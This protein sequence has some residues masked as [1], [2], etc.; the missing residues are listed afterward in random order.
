ML[1]V[2]R[3]EAGL[4]VGTLML[5]GQARADTPKQG[6]TIAVATA[7]EPPTLDPMESP[8]DVVG[9]IS[10]H[11]FETLYTWGDGW[12]IVPLLAA[13]MP[14]ISE[15]GRVYTI[16]LRTGVAFHDGSTMTSADVL[17]SLQRWM[18]IAQRGQQTKENVESVTAPDER[19]IRIA[20]KQP[21]AP[22]LSL[23]ALQTSAAI[24]IPRGNQK[25]P[26]TD[27]I[28]TGPYRF[29]ARMPDRY[30]QLRRFDGYVARTDAPSGYGGR[31]TPLLDE[32]R[33]V[34]VPSAAT[35]V[36][37]ALAGQFDYADALPVESLDR[38]KS[39]PVDPIMFPA[40]GWPLFFVNHR[41]GP[42]T[43]PALRRAV[44]ASLSFEDMLAAAFGP[45]FYAADG[46]YYPAGFQ[47]H[48]DAGAEAYRQ[49]GDAAR[50]RRLAADAGYHGETIRI[51]VSQQY[52]FHYKLA[53]V[54]ANFMKE[55][56]FA[57]ELAV[58]DWATLLTQRNQ[59]GLWEMFVT[60]G[61]ILPEPTLYS[62]MTP[63]APGWW[64]TPAR[65]KA[66]DAFNGEPDP[67]RRAQLWGD[68][69]A[70]IYQEVPIIR[71]GNFNALG[72]RSKRLAGLV[73]A[74]WPFFWNVW[75]NA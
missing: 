73:P 36:E 17:A 22:L 70:L 74:A 44:L 66:V 4:L 9:I 24:I 45:G 27:Y 28:G 51:M 11:I 14:A 31:R 23:L 50:A 68:V 72:V 19:T 25:Q 16:P 21:F 42:L 49:A 39:G 58:V 38:L 62:F 55:A 71:I 37:G 52:D 1:L 57:T 8:A 75:V 13:E 32:I 29:V 48:S 26:M 60:H 18:S 12:R 61:P 7:G 63:A 56:G 41:Q 33:F 40:F 2:T 30:I 6:G 5:A 59:P 64:S 47:L 53:V 67:A 15:G 43:N 46:A 3:R 69:Q 35:R 10:Q 65:D 54:A 34:P 20:L